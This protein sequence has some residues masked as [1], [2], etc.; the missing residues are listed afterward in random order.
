MAWI[1]YRGKETVQHASIEL[2]PGKVFELN[3]EAAKV[4][5]RDRDDCVLVEGP[6]KGPEKKPPV[7]GEGKEQG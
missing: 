2:V 7:K 6:K 1:E 5:T 4:L 3:D